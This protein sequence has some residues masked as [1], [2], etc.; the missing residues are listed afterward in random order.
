MTTTTTT[1]APTNKIAIAL[2]EDTDLQINID[3]LTELAATAG[4]E[5]AAVFTQNRPTADFATYLGS[6]K[7]KEIKES[8]DAL[9]IDTI[10]FNDELTPIQHA[11]LT[12]QLDAEV[13]DR[14]NL[15]LHIFS[16]RART[17]EG[18]IQV[19]LARLKYL[20]PR[21]RATPGKLSRQ[22]AGVLARGPGETKLETDKRYL[23]EQIRRLKTEL[24]E[25]EKQ[26]DITRTKREK[27]QIPLIALVGYTNAGK[28]TL[29]NKLTGSD[30]LT[31][32]KL[33]ATLDTTVR[34]TEIAPDLFVLISD[35]VGFIRNLPHHLIDSFK[36][37]L[38][39]TRFADIILNVCDISNPQVFEH[40]KV[41]HN[42]LS[43][44]KITERVIDVYNKSDLVENN[45]IEAPD[46]VAVSALTGQGLQGLKDMIVKEIKSK[47]SFLTVLLPY[48]EMNT[49]EKL[50]NYSFDTSI[51]YEEK[52]VSIAGYFANKH[53]KEW[54]K[55]I[56]N[57]H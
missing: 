35:T 55:F 7:V 40:N 3:E 28:S 49:L 45:K 57:T 36:S 22:G 18:K 42:Q 38:E 9:K 47:Y 21:M 46:A 41:T 27:N 53:L 1:T 24:A 54:S 33:F 52:G 17:A 44:L 4:L 16:M 25:I 51:Q 26:R 31:E 11:N 15:I 12:D 10:I 30:V 23:R 29:F 20:L 19:E 37:T 6:G 5:V 8:L 32:D 56:Q 13:M 34:R 14:T 39:E 50:L 43:E 48:A 2:I